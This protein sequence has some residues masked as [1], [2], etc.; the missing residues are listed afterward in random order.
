MSNNSS[1]AQVA[2]RNRRTATEQEITEQTCESTEVTYAEAQA[3]AAEQ[4]RQEL[5]QRLDAAQ[6]RAEAAAKKHA[7][8]K[9]RFERAVALLV[10]SHPE[11]VDWYD[12][13]GALDRDTVRAA[14]RL[15]TVALHRLMER[16]RK[17]FPDPPK[18]DRLRL[19]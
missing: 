13:P 12:H 9:A 19:P 18:H 10:S 14:A 16:N 4:R 17:R 1:R 15:S 3:I 2:A 6:A 5:V 8:E 11:R 7:G